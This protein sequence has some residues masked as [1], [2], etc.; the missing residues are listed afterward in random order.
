MEQLASRIDRASRGKIRPSHITYASLVLHIPIAWAIIDERFIAAALMLVV[1]GLMDT[2][3]GSL[4]RQQKSSSESG[5]VLDSSTDRIKEAILYI[6]ISYYFAS[7]NHDFGTALAT[8]AACGSIVTSYVRARGEIALIAKEG[9]SKKAINQ[10]FKGG[11]MSYEVRMATLVAGLLSSQLLVAVFAIAALS[12]PTAFSR[13]RTV[14][15][16]LS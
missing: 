3:D 15:R 7:I 8:A 13:L 10:V 6:A 16:T 5:M 12:W 1:F 14:L 2:L 11:L 4:A 9:L